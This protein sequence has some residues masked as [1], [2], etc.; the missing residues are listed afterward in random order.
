MCKIRTVSKRCLTIQRVYCISRS[1]ILQIKFKS[2]LLPFPAAQEKFISSSS[3]I[4]IYVY[5]RSMS[6]TVEFFPIS[7]ESLEHRPMR[8]FN[9]THLYAMN[10]RETSRFF[11]ESYIRK[12]QFSDIRIFTNDFYMPKEH[13]V[14]PIVHISFRR[15]KSGAK[16]VVFVVETRLRDTEFSILSVESG[17][18]SVSLFFFPRVPRARYLSISRRCVWGMELYEDSRV[19]TRQ[20]DMRP[21]TSGSTSETEQDNRENGTKGTRRREEAKKKRWRSFIFALEKKTFLRI[22]ENGG[23]G[24]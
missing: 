11:H 24:R 19:P 8:M 13:K 10:V 5:I 1:E 9:E 7:R 4:C 14:F 12:K 16:L 21:R 6:I 22:R 23:T 20:I 18:L 3:I 15:E 17:S 2:Q